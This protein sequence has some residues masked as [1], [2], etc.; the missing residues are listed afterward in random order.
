MAI[1]PYSPCLCGSG[2]KL[3]FCCADIAAELEKIQRMLEGDQRAA[4]LE[5]IESIEPRFPDRASLLSIKGMLQ[6]QLGQ[7]QAAKA[8][9]AR[10]LEKYPDNP[11]AMAEDATMKAVE[12]GG[13]AAVG[14]L[15]DALEHCDEQIPA[16]VYDAIGLIAQALIAE[17]Q[18]L[19]ARAHLVLQVGMTGTKDQQPLQLLMRLNSS[20]SVPLL[21]KQDW[22]P[23][24]PPDDALWKNSFN[25]A[26][27][28][29]MRGA[30][31]K[32]A[33]ELEAL[34]AKVGDWPAI[35]RN[36]AVLRTWLADTPGAIA[37]WKRYSAQPIP[38]DDAIE[39]EALAQS[40]DPDAVDL[41]D[42][43]SIEY[44]VKDM[45]VL[46]ARLIANPRAL[47]MPID[48]ARMGTEDSPPPKGA[49]WLLSRAVPQ[50][51]KDLAPADVPQVVGQAFIYGK[52]TD[53]AA[54]LELAA[55]RTQLADAQAALTEVAGDSLGEKV[56]EEI[57]TEV[58]A[59]QHALTTNW[60]LPEDTSPEKRLELI[61][62]QRR[63]ILLNHWP[64]MPRKI[65]GGKSA[66]EV[67]G[68]PAQ[69]IKLLAAI[70]LLEL[71]TDQVA[72]DFDFN[73]LRRQL[74]VDEAP[75]IDPATTSLAE[76]P[77][78]RMGR[79]DLKK[80][81]DDQLVD[82]YQRADH[83]RHIAALR[84]LAH[85][86]IA[87]PGLDGKLE[88]AEVYGLLA[89]I[90]PDSGQAVAYLDKARAAADAAK[91]STAP[92]DLAE[93][94]L[95]ISRGEVADADRLLHHIRDQ[96]M[97]EPGVAQALYQILTEAGIIGPD[98]RPTMPP[99]AGPQG[100]DI[101]VAGGG[102]EPG[103]LWT[104]GSDEPTGGKKSAIWTPD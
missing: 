29:A 91:K 3:K 80:L 44:G 68:D 88:K 82:L 9:I 5:Y 8:T 103:K 23:G 97:R 73:E 51:G 62:Q 26:L 95:R 61:K 53:R 102:A 39:A 38:L 104:P 50:S 89:Q 25:Q 74:G 12:E 86:V 17:N 48:L 77:L 92:W 49:F 96:H 7:E 4:C 35:W 72:S 6:A 24:P 30:W 81:S 54:R 43:L 79:V 87:R 64:N 42:V 94:A 57:S 1:D 2:K 83:Y 100:G 69:K 52:Q 101:G 99:G 60:R 19:A 56:K 98:G 31:R 40:I 13:V 66:K 15:Q 20:T 11:V 32:A 55:Y 28:P 45:E 59:L 70:L 90:E 16:Q 67:A 84:H 18:L 93:L 22:S 58:P 41:V 76:L 36:I 78:A 65:F 21:A 37:A 71:A 33:G 27:A 46:Q 85:E 10:F 14:R 34:A 75:A 63:D 47:Q